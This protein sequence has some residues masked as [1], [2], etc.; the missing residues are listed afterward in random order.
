MEKPKYLMELW[1]VNYYVNLITLKKNLDYSMPNTNV[2]QMLNKIQNILLPMNLKKKKT[3][4]IYLLTENLD[5]T[6]LNTVLLSVLLMILNVNLE[7]L[8]IYNVQNLTL[9]VKYIQKKC[10]KEK[11]MKNS[12]K[13]VS[14]IVTKLVNKML[15]VNFTK[16][17]LMNV[18]TL[19]LKVK[20]PNSLNLLMMPGLL[21]NS[22][23]IL[24]NVNQL[25]KK[26]TEVKDMLMTK[27]PIKFVNQKTLNIVSKLTNQLNHN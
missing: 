2:Y 21:Y 7:E 10:N 20:Y 3:E 24:M 26:N 22:K 17:I 15:I 8:L 11:M 9:L 23:K 4:K 14:T 1:Y 16:L 19:Q 13:T 5:L 27:K 25:L 6:D 12:I 18:K